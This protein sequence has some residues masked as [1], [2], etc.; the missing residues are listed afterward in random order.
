MALT[1]ALN[2]TA[3]LV[4]SAA[5]H[6][7]IH[8]VERGGLAAQHQRSGG[9]A[10][11]SPSQTDALSGYTLAHSRFR[12]V[13]DL[14]LAR[15]PSLGLTNGLCMAD[16]HGSDSFAPHTVKTLSAQQAGQGV[17]G[18]RESTY[19]QAAIGSQVASEYHS[20][21][22][23]GMS[24]N[25]PGILSL[26]HGWIGH[27]TASSEATDLVQAQLA[28]TNP[29][30]S[31][32]AA[33]ELVDIDVTPKGDKWQID[34]VWTAILD[35]F[36]TLFV[37]ELVTIPS[38]PD[39]K[40]ELVAFEETQGS[41]ATVLVDQVPVGLAW[42]VSKV[43]VDRSQYA[44]GVWQELNPGTEQRKAD[45]TLEPLGRVTIR[46]GTED[47]SARQLASELAIGLG[48][49]G[50]WVYLEEVK[51]DQTESSVAY[52]Y[53]A[54]LELASNVAAYLPVLGPDGAV[55]SVELAA[56]PGEV[57]VTLVGGPTFVDEAN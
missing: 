56:A 23:F 11:A 1:C 7:I 31:T 33:P 3:C 47:N 48:A 12:Q 4:F 5:S 15:L 50:V 52:R 20:A 25:M 35:P 30:D 24:G 39:G 55:Q 36:E 6:A 45:V 53:A 26:P 18:A 49:S 29:D 28:V 19:P 17:L 13:N 57:V 16:G 22:W 8:D 54:D 51:L 41:A 37:V 10:S 46:V 32:M 42:R 43:A 9:V 40:S 27:S 2:L 34:F 38:A 44:A 14:P 21:L